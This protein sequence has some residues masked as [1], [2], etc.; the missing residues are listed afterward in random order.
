M[1]VSDFKYSDQSFFRKICKDY[2]KYLT[3]TH[4]KGFTAGAGNVWT[5]GQIGSTVNMVFFDG[6]EGTKVGLVGDVDL[7]KEWF[8]TTT[9]DVLTIYSTAD[10]NDDVRIEIGEDKDTFV[11]QLLADASQELNSLITSH[12]VPIPMAM[13]YD[14]DPLNAETPEYDFIIKKAECL[15]AY[16]NLLNSNG[17]FEQ[18]DQVY[19]QVTNFDKTG[20]V[21]RINSGDIRLAYETKAVSSNG[22]II[23]SDSAGGTMILASLKGSWSGEFD[24][25]KIQCTQT[26]GF[27]VGKVSIYTKS[28]TELYGNFVREFVISGAYQ[29]LAYG[30]KGRFSGGSIAGG[31]IWYVEGGNEKPTNSELKSIHLWR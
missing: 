8:Y 19:N 12:V 24:R 26:G 14:N 4:L 9:T 16:S 18:A 13:I 30:I 20:I 31:D 15:I 29:E 21:D 25:I 28:S 3:R 17:E 6:L 22:R 7:A 27:G 11:N 10:P 1:A 23:K 2:P 5:L